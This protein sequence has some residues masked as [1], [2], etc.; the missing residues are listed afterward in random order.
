MEQGTDKRRPLGVADLLDK[1]TPVVE[2][3]LQTPSITRTMREK[4]KTY[5]DSLRVMDDTVLDHLL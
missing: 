2:N 3:F 5:V 4:K 1:E